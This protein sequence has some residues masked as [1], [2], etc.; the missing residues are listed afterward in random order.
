[1]IYYSKDEM[2]KHTRNEQKMHAK[3]LSQRLTVV[4]YEKEQLQMQLR[5]TTMEFKK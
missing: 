3:E 5:D 4:M 2:L 1:M